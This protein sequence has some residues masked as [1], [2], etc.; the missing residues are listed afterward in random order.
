MATK[1][2]VPTEMIDLPSKGMLYPKDNLLSSGSVEMKYMTA[3][4][5]DILTNT[6]LLRQGLAIDNMLKSVIKTPIVYEDLTIGDRNALM[7]ASRILGY[8]K[9]YNLKVVNPNTSIEESVVVDL[10]TLKYKEVDYTLLNESNEFSYE[11]PFT[12]NQ[13]TFKVLT[14]GDDKKIDDEAKA[15]KKSLGFQPGASERLKYQITSVNGDRSQKTIRDFI[16]SGALLARDSNPLR[17]YMSSVTPDIDMKATVT[18][19]D[20]TDLEIDVPMLASFFFPG[21][22]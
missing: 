17:Q 12:K 3:K 14:V 9:N 16:E 4:E 11:L 1:F 7:I 22:D 19:Q 8:G 21:L 15:L 6:N 20:G 18:F 5:E 10:Q 13:V 2:E